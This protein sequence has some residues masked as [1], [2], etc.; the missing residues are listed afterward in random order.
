MKPKKQTKGYYDYNQCRNYL[1][2][3]YNYDERDYA[4]KYYRN[5][6]N[7]ITK[8]NN[9]KPYLDFWC[10]V[11]DNY[12]INNGCFITFYKNDIKQ[13]K[14]D[15]IKEIYSHY[16]DEFADENGELEMYIWW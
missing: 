6:K 9:D 12:T 2:D 13:I 16:I 15:W 7:K 1:Q 5:K 11:L 10:W 8:V 4:K 3:K 14:E